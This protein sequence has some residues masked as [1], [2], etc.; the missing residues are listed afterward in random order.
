M[1]TLNK[2]DWDI[3]NPELKLLGYFGILAALDELVFWMRRG[4]KK[5]AY[6]RLRQLADFCD[7]M[8]KYLTPHKKNEER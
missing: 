8:A 7:I 3:L 2:Q 5:R 6:K 4:D 1:N